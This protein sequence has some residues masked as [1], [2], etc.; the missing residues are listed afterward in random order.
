ML[1]KAVGMAIMTANAMAV[2]MA[3]MTADVAV[4]WGGRRPLGHPRCRPHLVSMRE[5]VEQVSLC[6]GGGKKGG[7]REKREDGKHEN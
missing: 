6:M 3:V 5:P 1:V 4:E 2:V 7:W